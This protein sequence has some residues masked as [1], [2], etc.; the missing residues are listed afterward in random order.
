M[1][2]KIVRNDITKMQCDAIVNTANPYVEVGPGCDKA[3]YTAAGYEQLLAARAEIGEM[4]PGEAAITPGFD[5][6]AKYIIHAV[7]PFFIDGCSGEEEQLRNCYK[8]SLH[9]ALENNIASI[10]FPLIS[11]GSFGYPKEAGLRIALDEINDFLISHEMDI[12]I[13]VFEDFATRLAARI[14][15][16]LE[17]YIDRNYVQEKSIEE[18]GVYGVP[19]GI[20]ETCA[21]DEEGE[22]AEFD[23]AGLDQALAERVAHATDTFSQFLMYLIEQKGLNNVEVYTKALIDKKRFSKIK[24]DIYYHPSK[25]IALQ[26]CVG[27]E[28]NIDQTNDLLA[29]AGYAL[30]P[31]DL[32]DIIFEYYIE[33]GHF[34]MIDIDIKL[35]EYGLPCVVK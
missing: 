33:M 14:D 15:K 1:S 35:E 29:R 28:L 4:Q 2:L 6:P 24:N 16:N 21:M 8:N 10:A 31:C 30:S 25:I 19:D 27:A 17:E 3:I 22:E 9:I 12:T 18:Y 5:L 32:T 23:Y 7:S 26:L 11:T 20:F 13:V 34:D